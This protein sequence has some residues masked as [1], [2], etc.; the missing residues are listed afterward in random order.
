MRAIL[1]AALLLAALLAGCG[2]KAATVCD[3][4]AQLE[5]D[6]GDYPAAEKQLTLQM[7]KAMC[8]GA[9]REGD[10]AQEM[11]AMFRD[12]IACAKTSSSCEAYRACQDQPAA[13][14]PPPPAP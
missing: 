8:E 1:V 11:A 14:T 2:D 13:P 3:K 9:L 4:Y 10:E 6:C 12:E 5:W 7:A